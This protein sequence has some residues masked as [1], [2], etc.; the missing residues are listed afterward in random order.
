MMNV[1]GS[2][3]PHSLS[4]RLSFALGSGIISTESTAPDKRNQNI[5]TLVED[6]EDRNVAS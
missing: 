6:D 3:Q 5:D 4:K 2:F 1:L